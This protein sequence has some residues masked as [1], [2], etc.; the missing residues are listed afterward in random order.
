MCFSMPDDLSMML[1]A[2]VDDAQVAARLGTGA[3]I[4]RRAARQRTSRVYLGA[5]TLTAAGAALVLAV[6]PTLTGGTHGLATNHGP[7]PMPST[8]S[9]APVVN[10]API[11][12]RESQT[13]AFSPPP[14][15][16][17]TPSQSFPPDPAVYRAEAWLPAA[18]APMASRYQ[19]S[20]T[21]PGDSGGAV[22]ATGLGVTPVCGSRYPGSNTVDGSAQVG[23]FL[24]SAGDGGW[25]QVI[26]MLY[27]LPSAQDAAT[28]YSRLLPDLASCLGGASGFSGTDLSAAFTAHAADGFGWYQQ[29]RFQAGSPSTP[30]TA[31]DYI[32]VAR[33]GSVIALFSAIA[34]WAPGQQGP[35]YD[36]TGDQRALDSLAAHLA[37]Y[38][39]TDPR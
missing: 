20:F 17:G 29:Y 15:P 33:H 18:D 26:E 19:W 5:G 9:K 30:R 37:A 14:S 21:A 13:P 23:T 11:N 1:D 22:S 8:G 36:T 3:D 7:A 2:L 31:A 38:T 35:V 12:S 32:L 24:A 6:A 27:F 10:P 25:S 39:G 34:A 28:T 16:A 4:R